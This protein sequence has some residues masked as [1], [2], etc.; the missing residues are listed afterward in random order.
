MSIQHLS[1]R[2]R[3]FATNSNIYLDVQLKIVKFSEYSEANSD[4]KSA[5]RG[6]AIPIRPTTS[7]GKAAAVFCSW[8]E[9]A[10][11]KSIH[12]MDVLAPALKGRFIFRV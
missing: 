1:F 5:D 11:S 8:N 9:M 12:L 3:L 2:L 6:T 4:S 10:V 7:P